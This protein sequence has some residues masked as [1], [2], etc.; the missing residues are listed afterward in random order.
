MNRNPD[1]LARNA[2]SARS[3]RRGRPDS[4]EAGDIRDQIL[5]A[6]ERLFAV[7][8]FSATSLRQIA[9]DVSVN[10][11][12]VHYY[13]GTKAHLLEAV[14]EHAFEPLAERMAGLENSGHAAPPQVVQLLFSMVTEHPHLPHL[15]TREVF[16]PGG[17]MQQG[18][19]ERFAPRLGGRLPGM[20]R[21]QQDSGAIPA[22]MDPRITALMILS[23]CIFPLIARPAAE[24]ALGLSFDAEG[25]EKIAWHVRQFIQRGLSR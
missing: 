23:L 1:I 7:Q 18:F 16:L 8:G 3:R 20:L 6:A 4:R 15:I 21:R 11:A 5:K 22:E 17:H 25:L 19:V 2:E 14:M 9:A 10:P 12:M 13:F 24:K